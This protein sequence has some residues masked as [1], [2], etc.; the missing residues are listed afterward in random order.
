MSV[1]CPGAAPTGVAEAITAPDNREE[2]VQGSMNKLTFVYTF[3]FCSVMHC[4]SEEN[5]SL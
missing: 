5:T 3:Q 4:V 2:Q 1:P